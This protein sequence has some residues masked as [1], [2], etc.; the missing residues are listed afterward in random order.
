MKSLR[1]LIAVLFFVLIGGMLF[2]NTRETTSGELTLLTNGTEA[3]PEIIQCI[4][5]AK[6][7]IF[8]NMFIWRD[9]KIGNYIAEELVEAADRGIKV[10]I[11]KDLYGSICEHAEESTTSFFHKSK[12]FTE[13]VKIDTLKMLYN[14]ARLNIHD[15]E[16]ELYKK[17]T[18]HPNITVEKDIFKADHSKFYIFD[19]EILIL[20]GINI[21]DKEN[22]QD[23]SGRFYEDFMIKMEGSLYV[24]QF[25]YTR[26]NGFQISDCVPPFYFGMNVKNEKLWQMEKLYLD[27]I[28]GSQQELT[29]VMAYFSPIKKFINAI[30]AASKRN[31]NV[32]IVLPA[33]ANFQDDSNKKTATILLKKSNNRIKIYFSPK[34]IHTKLMYNEN[35]VSFGSCN[36]TKKA[37]SQLDE[38]NLFSNN[39]LGDINNQLKVKIE[40]TIAESIPIENY[41][42]I[43]FN[44]FLAWLE[45][46][47]V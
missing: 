25:L 39:C 42:M 15:Q 6:K 21:E 17:I 24:E 33:K 7:S 23:M 3:F 18:N 43:K 8:I 41:K 10:T 19:D 12:T 32:R 13:T 44:V 2:P 4:K 45:G 28:N 22:G 47:L 38:L 29:I 1:K 37:F 40:N 14:P 20:G 27:L 9:D 31:V 34:M 30:L 5:N 11:S 26:K 35:T 36:I 46:F 16:T